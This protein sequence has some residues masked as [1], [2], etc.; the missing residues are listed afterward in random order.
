MRRR[1]G[2]EI[3]QRELVVHPQVGFSRGL[4]IAG[5]ERH[6][7]QPR[8]HFVGHQALVVG[9]LPIDLDGVVEATR[10]F[11]GLAERQRR[12]QRNRP[13]RLAVDQ[14]SKVRLASG[15]LLQTELSEAL[16]VVDVI[17]ERRR[18]PSRLSVACAAEYSPSSK[19]FDGS[20]KRLPPGAARTLRSAAAGTSHRSLSL[21]GSAGCCVGPSA[22]CASC[23]LVSARREDDTPPR[24][25]ALPGR[26]RR[27]SRGIAKQ[28]GVAVG[29][30]LHQL[31]LEQRAA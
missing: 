27:C 10:G 29:Q 31:L 26:G 3:R 13:D 28:R 30:R 6:G 1:R 17:G 19:S 22:D 9:N 12:V 21:A 8:Q 4:A 7:S 5:A 15:S 16:V 23:R 2:R 11:G 24:R 18:W 25:R 14:R 20:G